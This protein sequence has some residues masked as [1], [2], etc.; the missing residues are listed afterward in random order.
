[1][2]PEPPVS[3]VLLMIVVGF[4]TDD[5]PVKSVVVVSDGNPEAEYSTD[6]WTG[7]EAVTVVAPSIFENNLAEL[8]T[9]EGGLPWLGGIVDNVR[10]YCIF[11]T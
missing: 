1:M 5:G 11:L 8:I 7:V 10:G 9:F 4:E 2:R 3:F 6:D